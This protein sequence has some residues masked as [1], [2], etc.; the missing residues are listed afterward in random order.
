MIFRQ[1]ARQEAN[2]ENDSAIPDYPA[3]EEE[4]EVDGLSPFLT[5]DMPA[6]TGR[7]THGTSRFSQKSGLKEQASPVDTGDMPAG[8]PE[9]DAGSLEEVR[10]A[11]IWSEILTRKY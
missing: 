2:K 3:F 4:P 9:I 10:K 6:S 7:T 11:V 1:I 5:T 8:T